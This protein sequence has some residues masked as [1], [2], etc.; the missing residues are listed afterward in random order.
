MALLKNEQYIRLFEDGSCEIYPS[1]EEREKIKNSTPK[2]TIMEKYEELLNI[3]RQSIKLFLENNPNIQ[4]ENDIP[5]ELKNM[6]EDFD[7]LNNEY[8]NYL[9]DCRYLDGAKHD[10]TI[11][12]IYYP[13]VYNSVPKITM[14]VKITLEG[15]TLEEIY[16][17]AKAKERFG[18][19]IDV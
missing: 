2:E 3:Q 9:N 10:Y 5:F 8:S 14:R 18:E 11:M 12:E 13:D 1:Q 7:I 15:N 6:I 19:T 17:D 16:L 4:S